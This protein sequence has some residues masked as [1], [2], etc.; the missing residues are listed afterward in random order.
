L[1]T[2]L[3]VPA[4]RRKLRQLL[5]RDQDFKR[6]EVTVVIPVRNRADY[7]LRNALVTLRSQDYP[8]ELVKIVVVDYGSELEAVDATARL[9]R[10]SDATMHS[11]KVNGVWN[12]A[13]CANY[14]IKR[15]GSEFLMSADA[16]NI[17][18][19]NFL[20]A[21]IAT[22]R[23]NPLAVVY[24]QMLDMEEES[25]SLLRAFAENKQP[26][27]YAKLEFLGVPRGAGVKHPGTFIT[28][29]LFF[30]HIRGY[31]EHYQEWGWEDNDIMQRFHLLGLDLESISASARFMHQWHPKGEGVRDWRDSA[32]RNK[33]YFD[34]NA[35]RVFRNSE[36]WGEG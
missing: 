20:S 27:P 32:G 14:A 17:F 11:L 19:S 31:D 25:S 28:S 2:C 6:D 18:A 33:E 15:C 7:R 3:F 1:N 23:R 5:A 9:C 36:G 21:S 13:R 29:T 30:H 26:V 34:R 24:S 16:D 4:R 35:G 12:K 10:E 22:L 8:E